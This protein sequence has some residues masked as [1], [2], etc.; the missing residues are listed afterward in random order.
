MV[1]ERESFRSRTGSVLALAG[2]AV[3]LGNI[4]RFPYM[5][6]EYG[7]GAFLLVYILCIVLFSLP[8][9]M[10]EFIVGRSSHVGAADAVGQL[11]PRGLWK[12]YGILA[13]GIPFFTLCYYCVIGGWT[14]QY[15]ADSCLLSFRR[16]GTDEAIQG[17]FGNLVASPVRPVVLDGAF[18]LVTALIIM[19]GVHKGIE[20]CSKIMMPVLF[21]V[22][23]FIAVWVAIQPGAGQGMAYLFRPDF[24]KITPKV[25]LAAMGQSFYSLSI[26]MGILITYSS[27][28]DRKIGLT[29]TAVSTIIADFVFAIIAGCAIIPALFAY[30]MPTD[31]GTGL[32]FKTLPVVFSRMPAGGVVSVVFFFA[33]LLAALTSAMSLFEVP[34]SWLIDRYQMSRVGA[35]VLVFV[36][37][38]AIGALCSLSFGVLSGFTVGG[39]VLFD[40]FDYTIGNYLM[41]LAGLVIVIFVGWKMSRKVILDEVVGYEYAANEQY[42]RRWR[43]LLLFMIRWLAP[44]AVIAIFLSG[45]L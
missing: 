9:M 38:F 6:S 17:M 29:Q 7:G 4:W 18:L 20:K 33:V 45:I 43:K 11:E 28:L 12:H 8:I 41:P 16:A 27:Y 44:A 24:S 39:R 5:L 42:H 34:V 22:M 31:Q 37:A 25:F 19:N 3:G 15:L 35:S 40:L 23:I 32:V 14:L 26:G 13:V 2:S 1:Q 36:C 10:S 21:F 30:G